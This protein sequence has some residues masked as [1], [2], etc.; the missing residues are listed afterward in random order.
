MKKKK[1]APKKAKKKQAKKLY[2]PVNKV[3]FPEVT[4]DYYYNILNTRHIISPELD[5]VVRFWKPFDVG[6]ESIPKPSKWW[7]IVGWYRYHFCESITINSGPNTEVR[8]AR[9]KIIRK[10]FTDICYQM[11]MHTNVETNVPET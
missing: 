3:K 6:Y 8:I 9:K 1:T 7:D 5:L 2:V 11:A 4:N 10:A